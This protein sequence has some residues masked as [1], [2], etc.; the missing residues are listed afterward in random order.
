SPQYAGTYQPSIPQYTP[1]SAA[2]TPIAT[3]NPWNQPHPPPPPNQGPPP[4]P[5]YSQ[6]PPAQPGRPPPA[7]SAATQVGNAFPAYGGQ[8]QQP[9]TP[10]SQNYVPPPSHP[11]A[12]G[13]PA[14]PPPVAPPLP[15]RPAYQPGQTPI[16]QQGGFNFGG[17]NYGQQPQQ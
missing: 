5:P 2:A 7:S 14:P 16:Q 13:Q 17:Q 4:P 11:H 6:H 8:Q 3:Q 12:T 10:L 15:P 1:A 9:P